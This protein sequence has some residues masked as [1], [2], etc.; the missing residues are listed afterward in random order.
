MEKPQKGQ[1]PLSKL[2]STDSMGRKRPG[3]KTRSIKDKQL[4]HQGSNPSHMFGTLH[5]TKV[6][7]QNSIKSVP[8]KSLGTGHELEEA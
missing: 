4:A 6:F 2:L 3:S 5:T 1:I 7:Q 8:E